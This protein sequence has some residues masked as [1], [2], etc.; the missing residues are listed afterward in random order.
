MK[1]IKFDTEKKYV[2]DFLSL[3]KK[4][5]T[6]K[7]N[8]EDR[9]TV[10]QLITNTHPLNKYFKL[11]KF[12]VYK[13]EEAVGRFAI[14]EYPDEKKDCYLGFFECIKD[15]KVAKEIF[16]EAESFAKTHKYKKLIGPI[17][18]S[19]WHKYRLKIN[20]FDKAPYTGEPYNADYYYDMF[21]KNNYKVSEHYV[22]NII[23]KVDESYSNAKFNEHFAEFEKLGYKIIKPKLKDFDKCIEEIYYLI[24][25]LYST[26]PAF[27]KLEKE[28]FISIF[29]SY[30]KILNMDMVRM[31][32]FKNQA[33]G[34]CISV[35]NYSNKV[36]HLNLKNILNILVTKKH[37]KQ[38]VML[39]LGAD[40]NHKGLGKAIAYTMAEELKKHDL[41]SISA[42]IR[43]GN[44]NINYGHEKFLNQYEYV[45]LEK[46]IK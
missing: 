25:D 14:T 44:I 43:D 6:K 22:S 20:L 29:S 27:K 41:T 32:Y 3:P 42:L 1:I 23:D 21:I 9:D 2:N 46:N 31:A 19:F 15:N 10:K 34:F 4:I 26:F 7:N 17:D 12:I 33:V 39:Y 37:P 16:K 24:M 28:D 38:Y 5:Y 30:K 8:T 11:T 18:G 36:Y 45:L 40:R 13:N 35:P